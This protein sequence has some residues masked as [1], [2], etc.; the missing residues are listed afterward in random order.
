MIDS[1]QCLNQLQFDLSSLLVNF[2]YE[3]GQI[4]ARKLARKPFINGG[5]IRPTD[6]LF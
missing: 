1:E 5:D 2:A 4:M 6:L 3:S